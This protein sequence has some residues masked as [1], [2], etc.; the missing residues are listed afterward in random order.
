MDLV[1]LILIALG[2]AIMLIVP[3][4]ARLISPSND[5]SYTYRKHKALFSPA[6]RSFLGVLDQAIGDQ[7]RVLGKVRIADV[8]TPQK[9]MSR[10]HWQGAFNRISAKHFDYLLCDKESLNVVAAIELDDNSHQRANRQQ[11]DQLI[12]DA[13]LTAELPLIRFSAQR[14]YHI[15]KVRSSIHTSLKPL[16][17]TK[18]SQ[19]INQATI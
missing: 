6:E 8:I 4:I 17:A 11:R 16:V 7:Y 5:N 1:Q 15:D 2:L 18:A 13:C 12:T 9:G 3:F 19:H 14:S 10:Q